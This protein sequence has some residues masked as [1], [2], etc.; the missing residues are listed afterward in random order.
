MTKIIKKLS[1][2]NKALF[3]DRDGVINEDYGHVYQ[4]NKFHLIENIETLIRKA[5]KNHF[6]VIV[7]TNQ[8]GIGKQFFSE[9]D[10]HTIINYM[11]DFFFK[12]RLFCRCSLLL[13]L[14]SYRGNWKIFEK[15]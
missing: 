2:T 13:P 8:A 12:K 6:K 9:N 14:S 7:V 3:L 4:I 10:F 11:K 15:F 5:N 1:I